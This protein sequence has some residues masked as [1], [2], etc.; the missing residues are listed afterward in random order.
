MININRHHDEVA[1]RYAG[2]FS[3]GRPP[4]LPFSRNSIGPLGQ[5]KLDT[6]CRGPHKRA[7]EQV[8]QSN[9]GHPRISGPAR[10]RTE[11]QGIHLSPAVSGGSGLSLHPRGVR[12]ALAC[13]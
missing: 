4:R 8:R 6:A 9:R 7:H 2:A 12:D 13:H 11:D 10:T 5:F 3:L 1:L